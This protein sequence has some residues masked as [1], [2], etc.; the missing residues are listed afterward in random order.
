LDDSKNVIAENK[1]LKFVGIHPRI[2]TNPKQRRLLTIHATVLL[3]GVCNG[4]T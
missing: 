4:P 3:A 2:S 1:Y